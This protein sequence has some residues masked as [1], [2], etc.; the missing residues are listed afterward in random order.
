MSDVVTFFWVVGQQNTVTGFGV[1]E[2]FNENQPSGTGIV[3]F[4]QND[5][6]RMMNGP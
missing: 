3:E 4:L 5:G 1:A 6:Y 2:F